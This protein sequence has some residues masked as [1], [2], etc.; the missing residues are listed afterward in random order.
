[1]QMSDIVQMEKV[2][3]RNIYIQTYAEMHVT[4]INEKRHEF[5]RERR[6]LEGRN[7]SKK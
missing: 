1:M 7:G 6:G 3:L 4:T 2:I 5:E